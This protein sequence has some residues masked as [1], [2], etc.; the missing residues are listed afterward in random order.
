MNRLIAFRTDNAVK[1]A[2]QAEA[3]ARGISVSRVIR[4][5]IAKGIGRDAAPAEGRRAA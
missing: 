4:D 2:L 3:D 1:A 5:L